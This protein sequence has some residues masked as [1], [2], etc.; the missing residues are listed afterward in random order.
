MEPLVFC[1][2][3]P[4]HDDLKIQ[5]HQEE[6]EEEEDD[7]THDTGL[8]MWP[9][10]VMLS[11]RIAQDPSLILNR[12]DILELGAGC[13]LVGLVA[14]TILEQEESRTSVMTASSNNAGANVIFTDYNPTACENLKRNAHLN[15]LDHCTSVLG[16]DFFDQGSLEEE[17]KTKDNDDDNPT[18][19]SGC[20]TWTDMNGN[21]QP[22]VHVILAAD[23]IAYSND[24]MLVATTTHA[25][26]VEGGHA[27]I[28][29]PN[30]DRRFGV[31]HF[32][33]ACS[34]LGLEV[35]VTTL[36]ADCESWDITSTNDSIGEHKTDNSISTDTAQQSRLSHDL[37]QANGENHGGYDFTLF[38]VHKPV[39]K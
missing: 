11:R 19:P 39:S 6:E 24:A 1:I 7:D 23:V 21:P 8:V 36:V 4:H 26:L 27:L 2:P 35:H 38:T 22:Q 28:L 5:V 30:E 34:R 9:S 15:K 13:G 32:E 37:Q 33:E 17:G 3:Q 31:A 16:L 12:G 25:C 10:A 14:A 20:C 29:G 18:P